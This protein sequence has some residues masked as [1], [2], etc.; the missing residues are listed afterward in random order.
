MEILSSYTLFEWSLA[1]LAAFIIG[2]SKAGLKGID[3]MNVTLMA[4]VF[5]SKESTGIVLPLLCVAD[6]FAVWYY[7][8]DA[9][10]GHFKKLMPWMIFGV[11]IGVFVGKDLDENLFKK[12]M[13]VII[14]VSSIIMIWWERTKNK[15]LPQGLWFAGLTGTAAGITTM[16][17]NLAGAFSNIYFLV[18]RMPKNQ[19][20]G[21]AAWLF[22]FINLFKLPFHIFSWETVNA[23]SIKVDFVLVPILLLGF[24][25]GLKIVDRIKNDDYRKLVLAL[26]LL[27]GIVI[28]FR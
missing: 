5:G 16:L 9:E 21:T 28:F 26:T 7:R 1:F 6:I 2:M 24:W 3:I 15:H 19:F 11:L 12:I 4:L 27:G 17:G 20:I 8:R 23:S 13:A 10:W 25:T 18:L 22:L 14:V